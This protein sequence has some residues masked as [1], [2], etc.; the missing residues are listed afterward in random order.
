MLN[1][2][3]DKFIFTNAL[4][5]KHS[6]FY[7]LNLPFVIAPSDLF[8]GMLSLDD[9]FSKKLYS[10]VKQSTKSNLIKKFRLDFGFKGEKLVNFLETYFMASGWGEIKTTH[11]IN[12]IKEL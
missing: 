10:S 2:F 5:Y 12:L 7:L 9:D 8:L 4:K 1:S 6:N 11:Q 3:Y